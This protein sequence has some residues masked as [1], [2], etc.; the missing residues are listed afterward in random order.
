MYSHPTSG[1]SLWKCVIFFAG[2][3]WRGLE[4]LNKE[5]GTD[6]RLAEA[7][8]RAERER[9]FK[10]RGEEHAG[11]ACVRGAAD[12]GPGAE[13][14]AARAEDVAVVAAGIDEESRRA[15]AHDDERQEE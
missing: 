11:E 12:G 13:L 15:S 2:E 3:I 5:G 7:A 6:R 14:R 4:R 1:K 8:T 9:S 10:G